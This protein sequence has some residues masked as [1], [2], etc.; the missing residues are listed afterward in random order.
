MYRA[1][2]GGKFVK[3]RFEWSLLRNFGLRFVFI[4]LLTQLSSLLKLVKILKNKIWKK[5]VGV[6]CAIRASD[7]SFFPGVMEA[8]YVF[9]FE[10]YSRNVELAEFFKSIFRNN[11]NFPKPNFFFHIFALFCVCVGKQMSIKRWCGEGA[12]V[13]GKMLVCK[14]TLNLKL[15]F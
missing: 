5:V 4:I 3:L 13:Q 12:W 1:S 2:P 10:R 15:F 11:F 7:L 8:F 6:T 14:K 9:H